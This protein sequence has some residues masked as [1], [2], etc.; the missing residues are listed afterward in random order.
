MKRAL[1]LLSVATV[2]SCGVV[3]FDV[4]QNLQEQ[5]V[6]GNP[7]PIAQ[8]FPS[9][10][11]IPLTIDIKAETAKRNTGPASSANLTSLSL[12]ATPHTAPSGNFDFLDEVHVMISA[13]NLPAVEIAS[14]KP[15][16]KGQTTLTFTIVPGVNLLP[17]I[18]GGATI[19]STAT[20]HQPM[21][22]LTFDGA[23]TVTVHI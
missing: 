7:N 12:S 8:L 14:V 20:G 22:D 19:Q 10:F 1:A 21:M 5:V 2:A 9:L 6:R 11:S 3:S 17:Y 13:P 4:S 18:N 16:P 23:V 15:V